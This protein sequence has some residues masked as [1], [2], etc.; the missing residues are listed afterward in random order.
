[1]QRKLIYVAFSRG[2]FFFILWFDSLKRKTTSPLF[3]PDTNLVTT[4]STGINLFFWGAFSPH[5]KGLCSGSSWNVSL[6]RRFSLWICIFY[7]S[8]QFWS[9]KMQFLRFPS[10]KYCSVRKGTP[11]GVLYTLFSCYML[12]LSLVKTPSKFC[13]VNRWIVALLKFEQDLHFV[14]LSNPTNQDKKL[15]YLVAFCQPSQNNTA[16]MHLITNNC[17]FILPKAFM[18]LKDFIWFCLIM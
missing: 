15:L 5:G 1:M 8:V 10:Q 13:H 17:I 7:V 9:F 14:V 3:L 4:F 2:Y 16:S 6:Q 18:S 12:S 11:P